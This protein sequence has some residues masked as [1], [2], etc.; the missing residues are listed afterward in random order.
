MA[1]AVGL[2]ERLRSR[3][4]TAGRVELSDAEASALVRTK[5]VHITLIGF[6]IPFSVSA[7]LSPTYSNVLKTPLQ[8]VATGLTD[9]TFM[10]FLI[11][12]AVESFVPGSTVVATAKRLAI[13]FVDFVVG[14]IVMVCMLF[15]R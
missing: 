14:M 7:A 3:V 8:Q 11:G 9:P 1:F 2:S 12:G 15:W 10:I 13:T 4:E 5:V 6:W